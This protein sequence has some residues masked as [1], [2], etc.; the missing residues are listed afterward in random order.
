MTLS[1]DVV[2]APARSKSAADA[3]GMVLDATC[4]PGQP[5][6]EVCDN[7]DND[8]D[9]VIDETVGIDRDADGIFCD[10][11]MLMAMELPMP[12]IIVQMSSTLISRMRIMMKRRCL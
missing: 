7:I 6:D 3:D 1:F 10:T 5:Q 2:L 12:T 9:G 8:C 4:T 11:M